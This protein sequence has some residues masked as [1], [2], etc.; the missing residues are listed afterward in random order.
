[1]KVGLLLAVVPV[2]LC[3]AETAAGLARQLQD[4]GLDPQ[5]CYRV[6]DLSFQK[7]DLRFYL[8]E[9]HLIFSRPVEGRRFA[10]VFTTDIPGGDA[11][12]IVFPPH[13]SERLS[14]AAF[15]KTPN[16]NEHLNTGLFLFTDGT[17]E[18]LLEQVSRSVS[19]KK[20]PEAGLLLEQ[21]FTPVLK[22]I[23]SSYETR[24][25]QD[26]MSARREHLG[27]FY[28]AVQGKN[29]GN[30]DII[31]DPR[32]R[33]QIVLGQVAYRDERRF[34]NT[35]TSFV[36][37]PYRTG[38]KAPPKEAAV[39]I[40]NI[41]VDATL[42]P[43]M[44]MKAVTRL[45][46]TVGETPDRAISFDLS[47]RMK[48][49]QA[50]VNGEPAETFARDSLRLNLMRAD[51][52]LFLV[53]LPAQLEP[54]REHTIEFHHEGNVVVGAGNGVY[55]VAARNSWYPNRDSAFARYD[56][57]FRYPKTVH[58]V[59]TGEVVEDKTEGDLRITR[60]TTPTPVRF[61]G[62]NIGNYE[63]T[64]VS[65]A[66]FNVQVYANRTVE[67]ALQPRPRDTVL[68]PTTPQLTPGARQARR[69]PEM[70]NTPMAIPIPNPPSRLQQLAS[71]ISSAVEFMSGQLGPPPLST[72]TV[73]PI[74]GTFGQGFPGLIYLSTLAYLDADQRP[75]NLRTEMQRMF[76]S[77]LL[78]AHEVAHQWWGNLVTSESY[79]DEWVMESLANYGALMFLEKRKGRRAL[80]QVLGEYRDDL[81]VKDAEGETLESAGPIIWGLRLNS[82]QSPRAWRTIL[83]EKGSWIVH[84]LRMRVGDEAFL[85]ILGEIVRRHRFK[86]ITTDNFRQIA[87]E[88]MPRD[89]DDP[90]LENFFE[91]WVYG[92][93]IPRVKLSYTVTGNAPKMRVRG[94]VTQSGVS[95]DFTASVP[96]EVQIPGRKPAVHWV[97]TS[98]DVSA[99]TIDVPRAPS[100]VVLAPGQT[101][102]AVKN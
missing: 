39:T 36:S 61:A 88:F 90:K 49:T 25:V 6:R 58:L 30:F 27:F 45:T 85:K 52:E 93:G 23:A 56:L 63:K 67:A 89:S 12:L 41:Q 9:G 72:L 21:T 10:A 5:E 14:L 100:K 99:F 73:S 53:I 95:D 19:L 24:L 40:K 42:E 79:Q 11:E 76:F 96:V 97:R 29:L 75:A 51:N 101:V 82:S 81:L 50:L 77:E 8:T 35:W 91:Q 62:F 57:T 37:R 3:G 4:A 15:T 26:F 22:N 43:D 48:V 28:A 71:E 94:K 59:A 102:L 32:A 1:V 65:R 16:L 54:G 80:D 74:P 87:A 44:Q 47:R 2:C 78:H 20:M 70:M 17:G 60:R 38:Q 68:I 84:M 13:R 46:F 31:Y 55:Y 86:S 34:F 7:D 18:L 98:S 33:E 92:T 83:Y 69:L 64:E 66:G